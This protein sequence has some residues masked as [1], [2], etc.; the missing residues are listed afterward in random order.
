MISPRLYGAWNDIGLTRYGIS[1]D[2][3]DELPPPKFGGNLVISRDMDLWVYQR[4]ASPSPHHGQEN[5]LTT[6]T[7]WHSTARSVPGS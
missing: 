5:P 2:G 3:I 4:G 1:T 6:P 7:S